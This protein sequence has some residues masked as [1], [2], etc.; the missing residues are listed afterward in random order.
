MYYET[1]K[2]KRPRRR[3]FRWALFRFFASLLITAVLLAGVF[4]GALYIAPVS[5]FL[6][7]PQEEMYINSDLPLTHMNVLLM[8]VDVN[9][10]GQRSDSMMVLS[11][12]DGDIV[13]T[14]LMR[15]MV[16]KIPGHDSTKINAAHVYGG[17]LLT[18]QTVN[19]NFGMNVCKYVKVDFLGLV[20]AVDALGGVRLKITEEERNKINAQVADKDARL[21]ADG[22]WIEPLTEYGEDTLLNGVQA[23]AYSRIRKLDSDYNRTGR[24]RQVLQAMFQRVREDGLN[25]VQ[26]AKLLD[27]LAQDVDTNL[28]WIEMAMLGMKAVKAD[29][30]EMHRLPAPDTF[31]DNGSSLRIDAPANA[32]ALQAWIYEQ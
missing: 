15:D 28:S 29:G 30:I 26:A 7:D 17:P 14:S 12:G 21:K 13:L 8:G 22:Y 11:V 25:L 32:A 1:K 20:H 6:L 23:L 4:A 19:R 27:V 10:Y 9:N 2:K 16:V 24:Q 5:L 18:I 3:S 31:T